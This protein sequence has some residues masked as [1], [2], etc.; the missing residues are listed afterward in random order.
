MV[1]ITIFLQNVTKDLEIE[2]GSLYEVEK[3][4]LLP[5]GVVIDYK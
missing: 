4:T 3:T 2:R 1:K 5:C